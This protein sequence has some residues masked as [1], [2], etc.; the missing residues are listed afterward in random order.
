MVTPHGLAPSSLPGS[1][2]S[3]QL[4]MPSASQLSS[5]LAMDSQLPALLMAAMPL[6]VL[7]MDS[8][9]SERWRQGAR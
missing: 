1:D 8:L 9:S 2:E 3:P 4:S 5:P 7:R 6:P